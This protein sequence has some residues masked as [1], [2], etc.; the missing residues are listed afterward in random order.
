MSRLY[1]VQSLTAELL[2]LPEADFRGRMRV[3]RAIQRE[4]GLSLALVRRSC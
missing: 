1:A 3:Y 2:D 4:L